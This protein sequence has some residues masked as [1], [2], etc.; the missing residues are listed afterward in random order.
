MA[1]PE[2]AAI[3]FETLDAIHFGSVFI[4]LPLWQMAVPDVAAICFETL[5]AGNFGSI[6]ICSLTLMGN[7]NDRCTCHLFCDI[8]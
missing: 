5:V 1:M 3:C 7:G 2:V 6:I 4:Y 8:G